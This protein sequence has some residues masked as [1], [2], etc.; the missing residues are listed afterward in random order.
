MTECEV[1]IYL[2]SALSL[3]SVCGVYKLHISSHKT[4]TK[5]WPQIVELTSKVT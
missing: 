5:K 2:V 4:G 3:K 1:T